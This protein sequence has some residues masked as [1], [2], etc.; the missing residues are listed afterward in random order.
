MSRRRRATLLLGLALLLGALAAADVGGR[1]HALRRALTPEVPVVVARRDV[2]AGALIPAGALGVR[3]V[4]LRY[5]PADAFGAAADVVGRRAAVDL[6]R[7]VDLAPSLVAAGAGAHAAPA[8]TVRPGE[9]VAPLVAVGDPA[10]I[11]PGRRVDV[12]VTRD[13]G[14]GGAGTTR[15]AL[16]DVEVLSSRAAP[17]DERPDGLPRVALALR[18]SVRQAVYLAAAQSFAHEVRV[19]PRAPGD[20]GRAGAGL[21]VG[22]GL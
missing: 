20:R 4:P 15:L 1:E 17:G 14:S 11:A 10:A 3:R 18:V 22:H 13:D 21:E 6:A 12:V 9:R 19:L 5:A 7:G 8:W 2:R 16:Q